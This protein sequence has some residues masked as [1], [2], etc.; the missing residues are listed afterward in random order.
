MKL[1]NPVPELPVSDIQAAAKAYGEQMGFTVDWTYE[2]S[3]AG[4]SKDA[5]RIFLRRR[6][7]GEAEQ[8]YTVTVWLNMGSPAEVDELYGAW[9]DRG[10]SIAEDLHTT[11]YNL[12]EFTARDLDGNRFRVFY[13]L[14]GTG[15]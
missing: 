15:T 11:P 9:K 7:P 8:R 13:D 4:I 6:T 2:D 12:R 1:P 3:F 10:V 14:G 5:A